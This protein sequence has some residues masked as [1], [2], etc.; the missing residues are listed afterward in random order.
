MDLALMSSARRNDLV[1][2][3]ALSAENV[4]RH[5][6]AELRKAGSSRFELTLLSENS[7]ILLHFRKTI[8]ILPSLMSFSSF[9]YI[10]V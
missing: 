4:N 7:T 6:Q 1:G 10:F 8:G 9:S 3:R 5:E 2:H